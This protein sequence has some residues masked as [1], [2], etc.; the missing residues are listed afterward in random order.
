MRRPFL[1]LVQADIEQ[2]VYIPRESIYHARNM[3]IRRPPSPLSL[4]FSQ[5]TQQSQITTVEEEVILEKEI[6]EPLEEHEEPL[7]ENKEE[8]DFVEVESVD[9]EREAEEREK[10]KKSKDKR[11]KKSKRRYSSDEEEEEQR[12]R[13][14][15]KRIDLSR[16]EK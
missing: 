11:S 3:Q 16:F 7:E 10:K 2:G 4:P 9:L 6:E 8:D 5:S 14:R 13:R 15:Q 1:K 12:E